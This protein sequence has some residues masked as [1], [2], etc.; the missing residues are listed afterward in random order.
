MSKTM[1]VRSSDRDTA[2]FTVHA[3]AEPSVMARALEL[4][5]KRG[6]IPDSFSCYR[7]GENGAALFM[8]I[9]M[10]GLSPA[11][12]EYVAACLR[13]LTPVTSVT[14][15]WQPLAPAALSA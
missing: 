5:T 3:A 2:C 1:G 4:F 14:T 10:P 15:E 7:H 13:Q 6:L 9:R 8:D 12:A 11:T